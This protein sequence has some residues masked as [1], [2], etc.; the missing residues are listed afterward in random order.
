MTSETQWNK[1]R[2]QPR[3]CNVSIGGATRR[4]FHRARARGVATT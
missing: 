1:P 2:R 4:K 3:C